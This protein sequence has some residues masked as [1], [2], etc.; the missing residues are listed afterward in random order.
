MP[1]RRS[2][3]ALRLASAEA[4]LIPLRNEVES[5]RVQALGWRERVRALEAR[6]ADAAPPRT[7]LTARLARAAGF[8]RTPAA[9]PADDLDPGYYRRRYRDLAG[10][11]DAELVTHWTRFGRPEGRRGRSSLDSVVLPPVRPLAA[12]EDTVVVVTPEAD[13]QPA[14]EL[15]AGLVADLATRHRVVTVV[16]RGGTPEAPAVRDADAAVLLDDTVD[17]DEF[18]AADLVDRLVAAYAPRGAVLS[19]AR[20]RDFAAAFEVHGVSAVVLIQEFAEEVVPRGDLANLV[21]TASHLVFPSAAARDSVLREHVFLRGR[22]LPVVPQG[23][24]RPLAP[25]IERRPD[26]EGPLVIAGAGPWVPEGGVD[27]F[28]QVAA[29]MPAGPRPVTFVWLG[30]EHDDELRYADLVRAQARAGD[31]PIRFHRLDGEDPA[32]L[33]ARADVFLSTARRE[34]LSTVAVE[35]LHAGVPVVAF[36]GAGGVAEALAAD[37]RTAHLVVP[38]VDSAAAAETLAALLADPAA[39]GRAGAAAQEI[40]RGLYDTA[41]YARDLE[42]LLATS[43]DERA[44]EVAD[45]GDL[46]GTG[47]FEPAFYWGARG[48]RPDDATALAHYL[49]TSRL[50]RPRA[51]ALSGLVGRKGARGFHPLVFAE[52]RPGADDHDPLAEWA[53]AGR[54]EGRWT[55]RVIRRDESSAPAAGADALRIAVHAH[56]FYPEALPDLLARL[57]RTHLRP[58]L[59]LTT[60]TEPKAAELRDGLA[61]AGLPGEV[62]VVPNA[63]RDVGPLLTGIGLERLDG[64]DLL[65]HVHGKKS[66]HAGGGVGDVWRDFLFGTLVA[67]LDGGPATADA[68]VAAF[69]AD[70]HLG[71]VFPEDANLNDWDEN[72]G[73]AEALAPRLGITTPFPVHFDFPMG[74]MYW[75]RVDAIRPLFELGLGWDDYPAEPLPVDGTL[76]HALE[77]LGPFVAAARGYGYATVTVDDLSR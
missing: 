15:A 65:L 70:P 42:R 22:T 68:I 6:A 49:H 62:I 16:L 2:D 76:L 28:L 38:Y 64:F 30:G 14:S 7:S 40:A 17:L 31:L 33:L 50:T 1:D 60:D 56:L 27:L 75:A 53:R 73:I 58:A 74:G 23:R 19:T 71:I 54:P 24:V 39:A 4:A 10:L 66:E 5:Y 63:G 18:E 3:D 48:S 9:A 8:G 51:R 37:P 11:D 72:R 44:T 36:A 47:V 45:H 77:R 29:R 61:G 32:E 46:L 59:L 52:D 13:G 43:A 25:A 21:G 55:H 20:A 41:R 57:A 26:P 34:A 67:P 69:A 35:A 12:G